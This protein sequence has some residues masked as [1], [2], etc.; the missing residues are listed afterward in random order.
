MQE[1]QDRVLAMS[2][3]ARLQHPPVRAEA[4][5]GLCQARLKHLAT[6][7]RSGDGN[8]PGRGTADSLAGLQLPSVNVKIALGAVQAVH[9]CSTC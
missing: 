1:S 3:W 5:G 7:T 8:E 2:G 6:R 9:S 4:A